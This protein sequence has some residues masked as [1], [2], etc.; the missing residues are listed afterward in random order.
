MSE[1][2]ENPELQR[3]GKQLKDLL[4]WFDHL[5]EMTGLTV[6]YR[7]ISYYLE[8]AVI[9]VIHTQGPWASVSLQEYRR[10]LSSGYFTYS[11][12]IYPTG[13][14]HYS[15]SMVTAFQLSPPSNPHPREETDVS[16]S[17]KM[18]NFIPKNNEEELFVRFDLL[19]PVNRATRAR[20]IL[21]RYPSITNDGKGR[22]EDGAIKEIQ[23]IKV[24]PCRA[25][26]KNM[27]NIPHT[28]CRHRVVVDFADGSSVFEYD[29]LFEDIVAK[30]YL[31]YLVLCCPHDSV[32]F[33]RM[34]KSCKLLPHIPAHRLRR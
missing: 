34:Q 8:K 6:S 33:T 27:E 15:K 24:S 31:P 4:W 12:T 25:T 29:L 9:M 10:M 30:G 21:A 2:T 32:K 3:V 7:G 20:E 28:P 13:R 14:R 22:Q 16:I 1:T 18:L 11:E 23:E 26:M 19:H 17:L 5:D